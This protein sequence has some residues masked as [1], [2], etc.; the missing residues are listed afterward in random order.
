MPLIMGHEF[1]G[2]VEEVGKEIQD[3]K[4]GDRVLVPFSQGDGICEYC[5]SGQSNVCTTPLHP[6]LLLPWRLRPLRRRP[7]RGPQPGPDA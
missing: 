5:R 4:K 7:V 6:R 2:V 1:C 3:F